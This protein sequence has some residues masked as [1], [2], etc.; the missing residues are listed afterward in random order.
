MSS[1]RSV[2]LLNPPG[3]D[4]YIRDYYCSKTSRSD[5]TFPPIDLLHAGGNFRQ[6]GWD[7]AAIDAIAGGL[8]I[9]ET[10]S[11]IAAAKPDAVFTLAGAVS[12]EEDANFLKLLR[13]VAPH[14]VLIGSG[15]VLIDHGRKWLERGLL[16]AVCLD[17]GSPSPVRF[18][19]GMRDGLTDLIFRHDGE[20]MD[21]GRALGRTV[22]TGI[23]VHDLFLSF[24]YH[25]P[26][27]RHRPFASILTDYGCPFRCSFCVMAGLHYHRRPMEDVAAE[28]Q[29]LKA[30]GIRE[31]VVW[32]QT[33]AADRKRGLQFLDLLPKGKDRF[34]WTCLIRPDRID[35]ELARLMAAK[36][37]HTVIMG[38]ETANEESLK[39]IKKDFTLDQVRDAF[40]CCREEGLE[41]VAT[42]IVGLPGETETDVVATMD[43]I[44]AIDPD[45][46]SVH[47]AVPRSGTGLRA[48]M[49][50]AGLI[51]SDMDVMDQ[52]GVQ[53]A[54]SSDAMDAETISA[55]RKTFNR[56]FHLRPRYLARMFFRR[57]LQP[58]LFVE[59]F[60]QGLR[61]LARNV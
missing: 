21:G 12:A 13:P 61:L 58:R 10:L 47:T 9:E 53:V 29:S 52:S 51:T 36:G 54:V 32:D 15:D 41:S 27:A 6:R 22:S 25:F 39:A 23:P 33:F 46:L 17:F 4:V 43:F 55:L 28:L 11:R 44:C 49:V 16:D 1:A 30:A 59:Q 31:F 26:F 3:R 45:Y 40:A 48:E 14:A 19:A 8:S 2:L 24:A 18:A 20:V 5:Y 57:L 60:R 42:V 7:V 34:G 50:E 38:V 35:R 37:C 56:R